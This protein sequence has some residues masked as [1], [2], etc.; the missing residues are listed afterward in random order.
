[1]D[2]SIKALDNTS[3]QFKFQILNAL[4][5]MITLF[6][7]NTFSVVTSLVFVLVMAQ[8]YLGRL[9]WIFL[10]IAAL[11]AEKFFVGDFLYY[12]SRM[13]QDHEMQLPGLLLRLVS[14]IPLAY[15][16]VIRKDVE[17]LIPKAGDFIHE[18][19]KLME[20]GIAAYFLLTFCYSNFYLDSKRQFLLS[21]LLM[22][23]LVIYIVFH[24]QKSIFLSFFFFSYLVVIFCEKYLVQMYYSNYELNYISSDSLY[25]FFI[26]FPIA[27]IIVMYVT[28]FNSQKQKE[29]FINSHENET[30]SNEKLS[31]DG[32]SQSKLVEYFA[33]LLLLFLG[34]CHFFAMTSLSEF[35]LSMDLTDR[36]YV[37]LFFG[38]VFSILGIW[39]FIGTKNDKKGNANTIVIFF[40]VSMTLALFRYIIMDWRNDDRIYLAVDIYFTVTYLLLV[41]PTIRMKSSVVSALLYAFKRNANYL[42][43]SESLLPEHEDLKNKEKVNV[44]LLPWRNRKVHVI[45][46][47]I[48]CFLT[49]YLGLGT[50]KLI[51]NDGFYLEAYG[52][53]SLLLIN[54]CIAIIFSKII[55]SVVR[56]DNAFFYFLIAYNGLGLLGNLFL[57]AQDVDAFDTVQIVSSLIYLVILFYASHLIGLNKKHR[58]ELL[59]KMDHDFSNNPDLLD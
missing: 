21:D 8:L 34:L 53:F 10:T 26:L 11:T 17:Q 2:F 13:M 9:N 19:T 46:M 4:A 39:S 54:A 37:Y 42:N 30:F 7:V 16:I 50:Y 1:M 5:F 49:F 45:L 56:L 15:L 43:S 33:S 3:T 27:L 24:I 38:I 12:I 40:I 14:L 18:K 28:D 52:D 57:F 47:F 31:A 36:E 58:Q 23:S 22:Y 20:W 41:I 48:I 55:R 59:S 35:G 32:M 6:T 25:Y 29:L 44:A 51:L